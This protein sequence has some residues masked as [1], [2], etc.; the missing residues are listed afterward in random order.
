[1]PTKP[2]FKLTTAHIKKYCD[3]KTFKRAEDYISAVSTLRLRGDEISVKVY[4]S[5]PRPYR[6][7]ISFN[8][9]NWKYGVCNCP[10][11]FHPCKHIVAV[12]LKIV[13]EGFDSIEPA[14]Q[15]SL[16]L[17]EADA[18]RNLIVTLVEKKPHLVDDIQAILS[19][20]SED[21]DDDELDADYEEDDDYESSW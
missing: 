13:H 7:M 8:Q 4:G 9:K 2:L 15:D 18:L 3:E 5:M 16:K 11:E 14:L 21:E 17:L 6:V 20:E 12:L 19:N 1:M 10:A